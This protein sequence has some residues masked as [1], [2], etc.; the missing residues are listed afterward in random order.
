MNDLNK[1]IYSRELIASAQ[2]E[3]RQRLIDLCA[4]ALNSEAP[5]ININGIM[6]CDVR[7]IAVVADYFKREQAQK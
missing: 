1:N 6:V 2:R 5:C 4:Q 7:L 3:A